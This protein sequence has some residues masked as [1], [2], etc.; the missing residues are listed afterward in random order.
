[1]RHVWP[2]L[3]RSFRCG[4]NPHERQFQS[5]GN[6][7]PHNSCKG[8]AQDNIRHPL[9]AR[10]CSLLNQLEIVVEVDHL[11]ESQVSTLPGHDHG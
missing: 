3:C 6:S 5:A 1:M 9:D 4:V 10:E 11:G 2:G 7:E 8:V